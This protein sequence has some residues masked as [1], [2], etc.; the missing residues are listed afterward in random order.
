MV[1]MSVN[2]H[3]ILTLLQAQKIVRL[4][5]WQ[6]KNDIFMDYNFILKCRIHDKASEF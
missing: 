3:R 2:Y 1:I 4:L 6:M 5:E